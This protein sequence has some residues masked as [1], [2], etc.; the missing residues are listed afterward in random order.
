LILIA[1]NFD[2]FLINPKLFSMFP[3]LA[4]QELS[5][6]SADKSWTV[7]SNPVRSG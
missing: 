2:Y 7:L 6:I 1:N 4:G 3:A 5:P